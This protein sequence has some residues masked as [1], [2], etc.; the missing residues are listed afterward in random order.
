MFLWATLPEPISTS[1]A[2]QARDHD[3]Q[4]TPGPRFGAAG[5]LERRLRLPFTLAPE[6]LERAVSILARLAPTTT[7]VDDAER[8]AGYVA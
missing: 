7:A 2:I 5:L 1:L 3:L 6:E 4:L 8:A